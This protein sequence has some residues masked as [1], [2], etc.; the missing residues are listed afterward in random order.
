MFTPTNR[1]LLLELS[2]SE[3]EEQKDVLLPEGFQPKA[4]FE[5]AKVVAVAQDCNTTWRQGSLIVFPSNMLQQVD[6]NGRKVSLVSENYVLGY[7]E[8]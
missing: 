4:E 5:V 6:I 1:N 3:Q 2:V 7:V 8:G